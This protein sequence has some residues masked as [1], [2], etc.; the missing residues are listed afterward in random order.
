M[1]ALAALGLRLGAIGALAGELARPVTYEH[2]EIADNLLAGRGFTV[3]FLGVTGATSQQAP[4]Y[5]ALLASAYGVFGAGSPKALLAVQALQ[6][7]AGTGLVLSVV[8]LA[9]SLVPQR[10]TLGWIAGWGAAIYPTH[11]YMVTH[12]QVAVW[13]ALLLTLLVA[14]AASPRGHGCWGKAALAGALAGLLLLVEPILALALP[15]VAVMV[16]CLLAPRVRDESGR[17]PYRPRRTLPVPSPS[18]AR[19]TGGDLGPLAGVAT[20]TACAALVVAPWLW[21]NYL[22]HGELV[23]VK[24]TFGYAFWQ[25]NNPASWGT[26]KIP[27]S[28]AETLRNQHDGTWASIDRALWEARHETLYIDDVLLVPGGYREFAGLS[29]PARS[30]LLGGRAWDFIRHEPARYARL[31]AQRLRYFLLFDETNPKA[32]NRVYRMATVVWLSLACIGS[33]VLRHNWRRLWPTWAIFAVVAAFHA[34]TIVSARFRIPIEPLSFVWAAGA[35][36]PL[37]DRLRRRWRRPGAGGQA[38]ERA[39]RVWIPHAL[40]AAMVH[41]TSAADSS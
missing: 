9:W 6:A 28:S 39:G 38:D 17:S 37:V 21:R 23:F 20:M 35:V 4:F 5:P 19:P 30:R 31:C 33:L 1:L 13:A 26:D 7:L 22:V 41:S 36:A 18:A 10:P 25:G 29:E 2:G 15:I 24:S 27:K 8:W 14:V 12:M 11:I 16:A 3:K 32:A 40:G 34:L